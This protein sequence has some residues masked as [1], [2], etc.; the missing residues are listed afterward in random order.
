VNVLKPILDISGV[1]GAAIVDPRGECVAFELPSPYDPIL[2]RD[3]V[4][5]IHSTLDL[6]KYLDDSKFNMLVANAQGAT[7]V[8]RQAGDH[9]V[10]ILGQE[11]LNASMLNVGLNVVC[12]KI[13]KTGG[14]GMGSVS[15]GSYGGSRSVGQTSHSFGSFS[16][17]DRLPAP[18]DAIG[19]DA[20]RAVSAALV[21]YLGPFGKVLVRNTLKQLGASPRT[22]SRAQYDDFISVLATKVTDAN[23]RR[24]FLST[25]SAIL[26]KH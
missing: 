8:A 23:A 5:E 15:S 11:N 24:E 22:L 13:E 12:L 7:L 9:T 6:F 26:K 10:V 14:Q 1:T 2:I 25:A 4:Q 3:V 20:V 17:Q 21:E 19:I 16:S 18:P